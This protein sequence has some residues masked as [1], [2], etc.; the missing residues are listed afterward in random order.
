MATSQQSLFASGPVEFH[1]AGIHLPEAGLWLDASKP[2]KLSFVSHGHTD[3]ISPHE[4][5]LMT[6]ATRRFFD[7][8][9][10]GHKTELVELKYNQPYQIGESTV[11][12][13]PA[14]HILGS[15]QVLVENSRRIVYTGDLKL[16]PSPVNEKAEVK[17][18][19][20]LIME[21]TF[22]LPEYA[23]P[24]EED[25]RAMLKSQVDMAL[26][27]KQVPIVRAY[28][29][30]KAQ[31]VIALLNGMGYK[32]ATEAQ[33]RQYC[34]VYELFGFSVGPTVTVEDFGL[35]TAETRD[36]PHFRS[37][38]EGLS[39][40]FPGL[41]SAD[42]LV[43]GSTGSL[44][45]WSE[46]LAKRRTIFVSGWGVDANAR[47]KF[48]VDVV[49]PLSDHADYYDLIEYVRQVE[50]KEVLVTHGAPDFAQ[51]LKQLGFKARYLK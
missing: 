38:N 44:R 25:T 49:I 23:F 22:G 17:K 32:V 3:H 20:I 24:T 16:R 19:D 27:S 9:L 29:L 31:E 14:G 30:G 47:Y 12:L 8:R 39:Q 45:R 10:A 34:D 18:C 26:A 28:A 43:V 37:G 36:C 13:F 11:T 48:G 21:A 51:H 35:R 6:A 5:A 7:L 33:I 15:A 2:Q 46:R 50:P 41:R 40:E 4:K 1:K 42:V